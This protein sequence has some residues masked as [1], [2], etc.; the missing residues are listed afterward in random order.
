MTAH[1]RRLVVAAALAGVLAGLLAAVLGGR[2][3]GAATTTRA[4]G[5]AMLPRERGPLRTAR[6]GV[7]PP[8][9]AASR[10]P[11]VYP[12]IAGTGA[13]VVARVADPYGGPPWAVRIFRRPNI[14]ALP[15][16][17]RVRHGTVEC[18]QVGRLLRGRFVWIDPRRQEA[19]AVPVGTTDATVCGGEGRAAVLGALRMPVGRPGASLPTVAATVFWGLS[20]RPATD[21]RLRTREGERALADLG[22]GARLVVARGAHALG[23]ATVLADGRPVR[24][25]IDN[26]P[27]SAPIAPSTGGMPR[28]PEFALDGLRV[29]AVVAD[30]SSDRPQL[31]ATAARG[32]TRCWTLQTSLVLGEPVRVATRLGALLPDA[33]QCQ[34]PFRVPSGGWTQAGGTASSQSAQPTAERRRMRERRTMPGTATSVLAF[35]PDV[36]E[37]DIDAPTGVRTV[38]T[39]SVGPMRVAVLVAAG[40][41]PMAP[42]MGNARPRVYTGRTAAGRSVRL[43][44]R[45]PILP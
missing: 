17:R 31:L 27:F 43:R 4:S 29:D 20:R 15:G 10:L 11:L 42:L 5:V 40:D 32:R 21:V 3:S 22:H 44:S 14:R 38:R 12:K 1:L 6:P 8:G 28:M 36:V 39:V 9:G 35:P 24:R 37:V 45:D 2:S 26:Q 16:P 18:A 23:R 19:L 34:Q 25:G 13:R 7:E 30:P 33:T 41:L